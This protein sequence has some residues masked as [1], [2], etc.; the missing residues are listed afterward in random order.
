MVPVFMLVDG[1]GNQ[2]YRTRGHI[3]PTGVLNQS[4]KVL[5]IVNVRSFDV[6]PDAKLKHHGL[7][8]SNVRRD[9][10]ALTGADAL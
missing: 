4:A 8:C 3:I 5:K 2:E 6:D 7:V 1:Y 9:S 10:K